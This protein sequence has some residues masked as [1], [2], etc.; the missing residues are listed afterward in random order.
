MSFAFDT[1]K[2]KVSLGGRSKLAESREQLLQR[3]QAERAK[4]AQERLEQKSAISIQVACSAVSNDTGG[5]QYHDE[6]LSPTIAKC[7][8]GSMAQ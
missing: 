7:F 6:N 3:T 4:R 5:H 8:A 1:S 2:R